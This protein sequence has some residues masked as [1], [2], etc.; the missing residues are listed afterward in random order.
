QTGGSTTG[1]DEQALIDHVRADA[2]GREEDGAG[3]AG[4]NAVEAE[5]AAEPSAAGGPSAAGEPTADAESG[6]AGTAPSTPGGGVPEPPGADVVVRVRL[7][8]LVGADRFPG[9]LAG[10]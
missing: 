9:E 1:L 8:T 6:F 4:P 10:M 2:T 7:S 5:P 3:N